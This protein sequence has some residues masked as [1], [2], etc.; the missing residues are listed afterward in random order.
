MKTL[1]IRTASLLPFLVVGCGG[2]TGNVTG[3]VTYDE[4]P[5]QLAMLG[6][7]YD[8]GVIKTTTTDSYGRFVLQN[9][10]VGRARIT[11]RIP[12]AHRPSM[13]LPEPVDPDGKDLKNRDSARRKPPEDREEDS[14]IPL[15]RRRKL[16]DPDNSELEYTVVKGDQDYHIEIPK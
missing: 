2:G 9:A 15:D 4:E 1:W 16:A 12:I 11:V 3:I 6:F 5:I 7:V 14:P 8:N 10:P 13:N